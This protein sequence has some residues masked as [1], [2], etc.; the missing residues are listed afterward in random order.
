MLAQ[1]I[2]TV[3]VISEDYIPSKKNSND[4]SKNINFFEL[5]NLSSKHD[6]VRFRAEADSEALKKKFSDKEI[7]KNNLPNNSS[8]RSL[9]NISEKIRYEVL[10]SK[11]VK[12]NF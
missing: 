10:G 3:K 8:Y 5:D 7:F 12:R 2:S 11:N 9:Y 6:F 4:S 1:I